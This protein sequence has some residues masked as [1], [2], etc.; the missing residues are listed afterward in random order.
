MWPAEAT[1]PDTSDSFN[2]I[3][4]QLEDEPLLREVRVMLPR[5]KLPLATKR[6]RKAKQ[7]C[8]CC[9]GGS[10]LE[11]TA[12]YVCSICGNTYTEKHQM[13]RHSRKHSQNK[14]INDVWFLPEK[15]SGNLKYHQ[16]VNGVNKKFQC[17]LCD[18]AYTRAHYLKQHISSFHEGKKTMFK[19]YICNKSLMGH[20]KEHLRTHSGEKPFKCNQCGARF[21]QNSQLTSHM[22]IHTGERPYS[23]N[24]CSSS[25]SSSTTLTLHMRTHT[26]EKPYICKLCHKVKF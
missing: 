20:I 5:L 3:V 22:R 1:V 24:I 6:Q 19:C 12:E 7:R 16:K 23:C 15:L 25:F 8:T 11:N 9:E 2:T 17:H 26:G 13:I 18:K 10:E 4:P 14:A 21:F